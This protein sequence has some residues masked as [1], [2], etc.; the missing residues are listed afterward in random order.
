MEKSYLVQ[1][2]VRERAV[3]TFE[4]KKRDVPSI[5]NILEDIHESSRRAKFEPTQNIYDGKQKNW[6][7]N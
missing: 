4:I 7:H 1:A 6:Q 3:S 5:K 2:I